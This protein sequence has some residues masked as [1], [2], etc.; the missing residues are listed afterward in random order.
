MLLLVQSL[1]GGRAGAQSHSGQPPWCV[2]CRSFS[3]APC[4]RGGGLFHCLQ[5]A[6]WVACAVKSLVERH[7]KSLA[8]V[9]H[10]PAQPRDD[11]KAEE[12]FADDSADPVVELEPWQAR[13]RRKS[14][15][16]APHASF[17]SPP[18]CGRP[19]PHLCR[20]ARSAKCSPKAA[21]RCR[22]GARLV[23]AA[24][25]SG[26]RSRTVLHGARLTH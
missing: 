18:N 13:T 5:A 17:A 20:R 24:A 2:G 15:E 1:W 11:W 19:P 10:E 6:E 14:R 22:W 26:C 25:S 8:L 9:T 12:L 23:G 7:H 3:L 21:G 4:R 16:R